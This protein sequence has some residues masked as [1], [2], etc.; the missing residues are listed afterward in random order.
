MIFDLLLVYSVGLV[1]IHFSDFGRLALKSF[2]DQK[3]RFF[4]HLDRESSSKKQCVSH[5][6]LVENPEEAKN[7][8]TLIDT[9]E[10]IKKEVPNIKISTY[11]RLEWLKRASSLPSPAN[12]D[13]FDTSMVA[14]SYH[15][16]SSLRPGSSRVSPDKVA[17]IELF[18]PSVLRAV[19]SLHPAG[20][21]D[22]DAVAFFSPDEVVCSTL[23]DSMFLFATMGFL[24]LVYA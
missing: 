21:K 19:V 18:I 6:S 12:E 23:D 20:S 8:K 15:P 14:Q 11:E 22:P 3:Q 2:T 16:S 1:T 17:V 4:P 13:S 9:L 10:S 7:Y 24:F 5:E